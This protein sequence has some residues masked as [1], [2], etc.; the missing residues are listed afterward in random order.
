M[1]ADADGLEANGRV[2]PLSRRRYAVDVRFQTL[3]TWLPG[4]RLS[5]NL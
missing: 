2:K 3:P 5:S 1:V 4:G